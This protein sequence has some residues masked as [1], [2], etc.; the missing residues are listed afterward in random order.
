MRKTRIFLFTVIAVLF[1]TPIITNIK[2]SNI[3]VESHYIET[4]FYNNNPIPLKTSPADV[5]R[6]T[7]LA[8]NDHHLKVTVYITFP[9]IPALLEYIRVTAGWKLMYFKS[10]PDP[11][12]L[13]EIL[14]AFAEADMI[15]DIEF[16]N[17][18]KNY[19]ELRAL[20]TKAYTIDD[21]DFDKNIPPP[22]DIDPTDYGKSSST[23][24]IMLHTNSQVEDFVQDWFDGDYTGKRILLGY[25][26]IKT[27][28]KS[29]LGSSSVEKAYNIK[30]DDT[31]KPSISCTYY[32][33]GTDGDPGYI[34]T[35]AS[36]VSGIY[37]APQ[38]YTYVGSKLGKYTYEFSAT[39]NDNDWGSYKN[40]RKTRVKSYSVTIVDDDTTGPKIDCRYIGGGTDGDPGYILTAVSD[41]SGIYSAPS[42]VTR[43]SSELGEHTYTFSAT[44]NDNDRTNDRSSSKKTVQITIVDDD[45]QGPKIT[46]SYYGSGTDG[47]P[48]YFLVKATDPSGL[49]IDP[50]GKYIIPSMV[51]VYSKTFKAKDN[52]IDRSGDSMTSVHT[53]SVSLVDD[54][55]NGPNIDIKYYGEKTDANPGY[56]VVKASDPSGLSIDPSGTYY[57]D[58]TIGWVYMRFLAV[59]ND[60]DR[61]GDT[62]ST[63][64]KFKIFLVDDDTNKPTIIYDYNG[65]YTDDNPGYLIVDAYDPSGLSVD[66]SGTYYLT[67][68]LGNQVFNFVAIDNDN[69]R[70]YDSLTSEEIVTINIVDDDIE[71]PIL[72]GYETSFDIN[73]VNISLNALDMSGFS[74]AKVYIDDVLIE[75]TNIVQNNINIS[76]SFSLDNEWIMESGTHNIKVEVFDGD[77][78][79]PDDSLSSVLS[80]TFEVTIDDMFEYVINQIDVLKQNFI[81]F[82]DDYTK[83]CKSKGKHHYHHFSKHIGNYIGKSM[84][85]KLSWAQCHLRKA[86]ELYNE[87][88]ICHS[89]YHDHFS[90]ALI[91]ITEFKTDFLNKIGLINDSEYDS[92]ISQIRDIR[93]N[94][95]VIMGVSVGTNQAV[96]IA[97][98]AIDILELKDDI[99]NEIGSY[100]AKYRLI[101]KLYSAERKL[102]YC[103]FKLSCGYNIDKKLAYVQKILDKTVK[104]VE[105]LLKHEIISQE[106]AE[107]IIERIIKINSSIEGIYSPI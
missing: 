70:P 31:S 76:I 14:E 19:G 34:K 93:N 62:S 106:L 46:S 32:G 40:D 24:G 43:V 100:C 97:Y 13:W 88:S 48:G 105:C 6:F 3:Q 51:G 47:N 54:D 52:D 60:N 4:P 57:L 15:E 89:L 71:A 74:C 30:D 75:T 92:L 25:E 69:D 50:S 83:V 5:D 37:I 22:D 78:D 98:T 18:K 107:S 96:K 23:I 17:K 26:Y 72:F 102:E 82:L 7:K 103:I 16:Y 81:D 11:E 79:R 80:G 21:T 67:P 101:S 61:E 85:R 8:Y 86:N 94:I 91:Q 38:R 45:T 39:D 35:T 63:I 27:Y 9:L 66:P 12:D 29:P 56:V 41:P 64:K 77:N 73:K 104:K 53:T 42:A 2:V 65:D 90:K 99:D 58:H 55:T 84:N 10:F 33:S 1:V 28:S 68:T 59:D 95:I 44:D 87:D 49:S 20:T 36:D